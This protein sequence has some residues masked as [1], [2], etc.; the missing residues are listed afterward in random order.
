MDRFI[1]QQQFKVLFDQLQVITNEPEVINSFL[2][3][4]V[5]IERINSRIAYTKNSK[6]SC[7]INLHE[8][9]NYKSS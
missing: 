5:T 7:V 2:L 9:E 6:T 4:L 8:L 1:D 3:Q